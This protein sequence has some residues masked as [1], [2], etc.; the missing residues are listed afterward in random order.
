MSERRK[1][2]RHHLVFYLKVFLQ[3]TNELI[4]FLGDI[5]HE[6]L[7]LVSE[8]AIESDK[9][10]NLQM[11]LFPEENA[12]KSLLFTATC[13]WSRIAANPDLFEAGFQ[14]V[15]VTPHDVSL[16]DDLIDDIGFRE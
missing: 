2:K 9:A 11:R 16:I 14:F 10:Y 5:T 15:N 7:L 1:F 4:G 13:R 3:E 8:D 6:G 12:E